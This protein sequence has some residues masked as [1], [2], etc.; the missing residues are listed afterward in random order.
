MHNRRVLLVVSLLLL[1][2]AAAVRANGFY[3]QEFSGRGIAQG[4]ATIADPGEASAVYF[5]PA[6]LPMM[7]RDFNLMLGVTTY[8][9]DATY[10]DPSDGE[11]V[12]AADDPAPAPF[13]FV[14][15]RPIEGL[16]IGVGAYTRFGLP[17]KW[18]GE[19]DGYHII[20]EVKLESSTL[21]V[22][23]AYSIFDWIS[24]GVSFD[25]TFGAVDLKRGLD[26]GPEWG[27][28]RVG[29]S[30][31]GF[32][33]SAGVFS[34][35]LDWLAI[36]VTY[37]GPTVMKLEGAKADFTV[38]NRF[39]TMFPDQQTDISITLPDVIGV[40]IRVWPHETLSLELDVVQVQWHHFDELEFEFDKGL[41]DPPL[42][43]QVEPQD[44]HD[45]LQVRLG[46]NWNTPLEGL[47]ARLGFIYDGSCI[48]EHR[49]N[50]MLPDNHR[51]DVGAGLGYSVW[52]LTFDV[53][54][55]FVYFLPREVGDNDENS[56]PAKYTNIS[57]VLVGSVS[58]SY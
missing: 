4:G 26:F 57:H 35:P 48:P 16:A 30:A 11:K 49:V 51:F 12:D 53:G 47:S 8:F 2:P 3:I 10:E 41:G 54:Y 18:P 33:A 1:L 23:A 19:W 45:A 29:G 55:L 9:P 38:P 21:S 5:N 44:W 14:S 27:T 22:A 56:F 15:Y 25:T 50:P 39:D 36:G 52:H 31:V 24:L 34:R 58:F 43:S 37:H 42:K 40:G 7:D 6:M 46:A 17:V 28:F 13:A 20:S 32:S